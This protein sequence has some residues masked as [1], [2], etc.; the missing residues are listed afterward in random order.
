MPT[1]CSKKEGTS[2]C[3]SFVLLVATLDVFAIFLPY[4]RM[5]IIKDWRAAINC[6]FL[7]CDH[8]PL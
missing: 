7:L 3:H 8:T 5:F 4:C 2:A 1:F 6:V